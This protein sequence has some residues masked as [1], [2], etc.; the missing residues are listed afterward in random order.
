MTSYKTTVIEFE[1]VFSSIYFMLYI[2]SRITQ[3]MKKQIKRTR[4]EIN[5]NTILLIIS[6]IIVGKIVTYEN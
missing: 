6:T 2:L 4:S 1:L 5:Y 3:H